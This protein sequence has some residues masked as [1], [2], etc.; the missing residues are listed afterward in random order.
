MRLRIIAFVVVLA[1]TSQ[2]RG[3]EPR[4]RYSASGHADSQQFVSRVSDAA[5]ARAP[6]WSQEV[7]RPPLSPRRAR[8]V[9]CKQ[10]QDSVQEARD[11]ELRE[12]GLVDTGDSLHWIYVVHFDRRYP[13]N[14]GVAEGV[15]FFDIVVL[16]DG[17]SIRPE[18]IPSQ[19]WPVPTPE[20]DYYAAG[21][22]RPT[23][24]EFFS[25]LRY[26]YHAAPEQQRRLERA[27]R[28]LRVGWT[29]PQVLK[30]LGPPDYKATWLHDVGRGRKRKTVVDEYWHYIYAM[31]A[32]SRPEEPGRLLIIGLSNRSKPRRVIQ[33]DG[34]EIPGLKLQNVPKT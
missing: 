17:I 27:A 8:R 26:P 5:L 33:V 15:E 3:G 23:Y 6:V 13:D 10:L 16:M 21:P 9:A 4:W 30:L 28:I 2:A 7:E 25:R 11:W 19:I 20:V 29:E 12:I 24:D 22:P 14:V 1:S 32:P 31:E 18:E 34:N